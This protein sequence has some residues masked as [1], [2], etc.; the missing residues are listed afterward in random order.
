MYF[1]FMR[2]SE[3]REAAN[4]PNYALVIYDEPSL[5]GQIV[6]VGTLENNWTY[7][8]VV[9]PGFLRAGKFMTTLGDVVR[10]GIEASQAGINPCIIRAVIRQAGDDSQTGSSLSFV[11]YSIIDQAAQDRKI[12]TRPRWISTRVLN[13]PVDGVGAYDWQDVSAAVARDPSLGCKATD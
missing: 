2:K 5:L 3:F 12:D 7:P 1:W 8:A 10:L 6:R 13:S 4:Q 11:D 9:E